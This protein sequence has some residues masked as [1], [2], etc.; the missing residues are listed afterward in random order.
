MVEVG[1]FIVVP[2]VS[3]LSGGDPL[4]A[5][6]AGQESNMVSSACSGARRR[7]VRGLLDDEWRREK[8]ADAIN[9]PWV[10]N[11]VGFLVNGPPGGAG[12]P[13]I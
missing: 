10:F 1:V 7:P 3:N 5:V 2:S 11:R 9:H 12:L 4:R 8:K 13:F 6:R